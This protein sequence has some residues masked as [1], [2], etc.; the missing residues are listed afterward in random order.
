MKRILII[1]MFILTLSLVSCKDTIIPKGYSKKIDYTN[2]SIEQINNT[3]QVSIYQYDSFPNVSKNKF[4]EKISD[5]SEVLLKIFMP[6]LEEALITYQFSERYE[7]KLDA[8][9]VREYSEDDYVYIDYKKTSDEYEYF[10]IYYLCASNNT[11]YYY[12]YAY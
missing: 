5:E 7:V 6:T 1:L 12:S 8:L 9:L 3:V 4:L 2:A 10:M 11:L